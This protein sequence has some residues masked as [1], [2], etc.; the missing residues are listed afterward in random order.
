M[1]RYIF[2]T[3]MLIASCSTN[4]KD[5]YVQKPDELAVIVNKPLKIPTKFELV[6]PTT[7]QEIQKN[8]QQSEQNQ[9]LSKFEEEILNKTSK[10][11]TEQ[12]IYEKIEKDKKPNIIKRIF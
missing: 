4:F 2:F 10:F 6:T 8:E 5:K 9:N 11:K 7:N 12:N 1:K 3:A